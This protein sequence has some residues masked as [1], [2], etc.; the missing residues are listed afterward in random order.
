ML[1]ALCSSWKS[2]AFHFLYVFVGILVATIY[3]YIFF[4]FFFNSFWNSDRP[5]CLFSICLKEFS[6]SLNRKQFLLFFLFLYQKSFVFTLFYP[7]IW[8]QN[9]LLI[10]WFMNV[11]T[12][13]LSLFY[14]ERQIGNRPFNLNVS[15]LFSVSIISPGPSSNISSSIYFCDCILLLQV[16]TL[17][18][19]SYAK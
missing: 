8:E 7:Q 3:I 10:F 15:L 12:H 9:Y 5:Y 11:F 14:S 2:R 13:E 17:G 6:D 16:R 1:S 4:F 19:W 18:V